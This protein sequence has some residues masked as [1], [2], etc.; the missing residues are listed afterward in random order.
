MV[1]QEKVFKYSNLSEICIQSTD[2]NTN[3]EYKTF[4]RDWEDLLFPWIPFITR[5]TLG[6]V[7]S[8]FF[9]ETFVID[10]TATHNQIVLPKFTVVQCYESNFELAIKIVGFIHLHFP[11]RISLIYFQF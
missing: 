8:I 6:N 1:C 9:S 5:Y 10:C 7:P 2:E 3:Y 11:L 4:H